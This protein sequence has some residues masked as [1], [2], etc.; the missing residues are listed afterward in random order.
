ME[1]LNIVKA[2]EDDQSEVLKVIND[3][4]LELFPHYFALG[5]KISI[6]STEERLEAEIKEGYIYK[7]LTKDDEMIGVVTIIDGELENMYLFPF[8]QK[9]GYGRKV[10]SIIETNKEMLLQ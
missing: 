6:H 3:I 7:V 10:L 2:T 4:V 1:D 5:D 8:Y 9:R